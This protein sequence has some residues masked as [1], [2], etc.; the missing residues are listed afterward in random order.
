MTRYFKP[1][2]NAF[3][4]IE[5][6]VVISIISLLIS[7][8][9]PALSKA[10][11]ASRTIDCG[12]R[13]K[14]Q[15]LAL[16]MYCSDNKD[17]YPLMQSGPQNGSYAVTWDALIAQ[18]TTIVMD[19]NGINTGLRKII[20]QNN[21]F[22]C[23]SDQVA[24]VSTERRTYQL[25]GVSDYGIGTSDAALKA[26]KGRI[27]NNITGGSNPWYVGRQADMLDSS[28]T[29]SISEMS[30]NTLWLANPSG[31][32]F[33]GGGYF[34]MPTAEG[35]RVNTQTLHAS[36]KFNYLFVDGHVQLLPP[37]A[38]NNGVIPANGSPITPKGMWTR[39]TDD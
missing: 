6:L 23:L 28:R 19:P 32:S 18:Y 37:E 22:R 38:T 9:L 26:S 36:N 1:I 13:L 4:L 31:N 15:G 5:L 3:T 33:N 16:A 20:S 17:Y 21:P 25:N 2:T 8:L 30:Y 34:Q 35:G 10:R 7:I 24:A 27:C 11:E 39:Y 12:N 29:I 14:Q